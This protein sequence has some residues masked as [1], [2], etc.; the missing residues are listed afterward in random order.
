[1]TEEYR[2]Y[3]IKVS[4]DVFPRPRAGQLPKLGAVNR[5][6]ILHGIDL[7]HTIEGGTIDRAKEWIDQ[8]VAN[9]NPHPRMESSAGPDK[10]DGDVPGDVP[11]VPPQASDIEATG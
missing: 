11:N 7:V 2:G 5:V 1:M 3:R 8:E 10:A 9:D 6:W 4:L